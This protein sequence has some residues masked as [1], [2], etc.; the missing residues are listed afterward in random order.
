MQSKENELNQPSD[1]PAVQ[2][3]F[4]RQWKEITRGTVDILP[5]G[6]FAEREEAKTLLNEWQ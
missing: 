1:S 2:R 3:E 5:E 4:E 6:E